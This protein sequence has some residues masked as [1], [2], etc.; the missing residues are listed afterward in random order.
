MYYF[1]E[2]CCQVCLSEDHEIKKFDMYQILD[3]NTIY[4]DY[5]YKI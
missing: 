1:L 3:C 2:G 5:M 4:S